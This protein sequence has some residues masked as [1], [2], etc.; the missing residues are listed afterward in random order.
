MTAADYFCPNCGILP[1]RKPSDP[2]PAERRSGAARFEGW[3]INARCLE[4]FDPT[5]VPTRHI[6]GSQL[7]IGQ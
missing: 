2:T 7:E 1:F 5:S 3:A 6:R 4:G